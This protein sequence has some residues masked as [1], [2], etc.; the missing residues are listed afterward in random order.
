[1]QS[2]AHNRN[3]RAVIDSRLSMKKLFC[4]LL[5]LIA[6]F[7]AAS[8]EETNANLIQNGDFSELDA[9]SMPVG[10]TRDQWIKDEGT[11]YL[12]VAEDET[13]GNCAAVVNNSANDARFRQV[14]EVEPDSYYHFSADI[15]ASGCDPDGHA[16]TLS[17][18]NTFVYS[19]DV[20]ETNGEWQHVDMYVRTTADQHEIALLLRVGGYS[21]TNTGAAYFD[22]V[23]C[24]KLDA[25]PDNV[26]AQSLE[27]QSASGNSGSDT[28]DTSETPVKRNTEAFLLLSCLYALAIFAIARRSQRILQSHTS[29]FSILLIAF[30]GALI[31]RIVLAL[32]VRG[33][34]TDINC[35]AAW[36]E[37]MFEN[38]AGHFYSKDYF[39]DYP[40]LYM[41]LLGGISALRHLF[42]IGVNSSAHI[43]L[44]KLIPILCDLLGGALIFKYA[45]RK[46]V[47]EKM[48]ALIAA[49]YL[50]NPAALI[51]SAAWGQIDSVFTLLICICAIEASEDKYIPSLIAFAAAMLI[52]PQAML[53]APLGLFAIIVN[54]IRA[55]DCRRTLNALLGVV[56]A[57]GLIYICAF[58]CCISTATGF[59]DAILRPVVW[60]HDLYSGTLGSYEYV[61][62]NALNLYI[63]FDLNW[64]AIASHRAIS[65]I[66]WALFAA[67]YLYAGYL[68]LRGKRKDNLLLLGGLLIYLI[69]CFGPKIHERYMFPAMLL[70]T[71]AYA[72]R[73][74]RRLL[75]SITAMTA[76]AAMNQLLVLQGGMG[77]ANTGHLQESEQWLNIALSAVNVINAL[78]LAWTAWD[79][80]ARDHIMG[81]KAV[82]TEDALFD[83]SAAQKP[84][85]HRLHI[86]RIDLIL[87][88][89][90]TAV[91]SIVAFVNLGTCAAPQ[92]SWIAS[93][94]NET[95]V[96]DLGDVHTYRMIYYG[97]ICDSTF[98]VELSNDARHWTNPAYAKY[99]RNEIFRWIYFAPNAADEIASGGSADDVQMNFV[100]LDQSFPMQTSRYI[101]IT[102]QSAGLTLSEFGFWDADGNLLSVS[103]A[104]HT[105]ADALAASDPNSL[106]DEQDTVAQ[107]PSYFNST[108][109]DEIYHARTA[110]ELKHGMSIYEYTH[111]QLGKVL[112]G[113]GIDL[114]GMTPFGW[115]FMGTLIG[116]LMVPLM[117][118]MAKQ[119]TK[120]VRLSFLA[121]CLMALDSMHF[122][123]TRIAT[124]DSYAVFWIML[125][126]LFMIRY[127]QMDWRQV[128]TGRSLVTLGLC[129][130]TMGV[131]WATKWI[132]LYASVGLAI[133]LFWKLISEIMRAENRKAAVLRAVWTCLF[134]VGFFV[135]IPVLIYYFSYYPQLRCEGASGIGAMF[136]K[137]SVE[138]VVKLQQSMLSYHAG[139]G[140]DTHYFRSP[141]YQWPIIWWPM[142]YYSGNAYVPD[143]MISSISCMGNPAVWW[144]GLIALIALLIY[145]ARS[146]RAK[147]AHLIVLIGFASQF[148][149]WVLV[150]RSTFIYHY[151]A[152]VPFIILCIALML[153]EIGAKRPHLAQYIGNALIGAALVMFIGFYPLESGTPVSRSYA[154]LLRW[155]KW[156]NY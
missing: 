147:R 83:I 19:Q 146:R 112:M 42:G 70:L 138:R 142:W 31:L 79:I 116:V 5:A 47:S 118:L 68:Y 125:M 134:C 99:N 153:Q 131:A 107:T 126:Y 115:R 23:T 54:L 106:I 111:P 26:F 91:Y 16:A 60:I 74:D 140:G 80:C 49:L 66:A 1:M 113:V 35:F 59:F 6:V 156:Y 21:S 2:P 98:T 56:C 64:A 132:G 96:F 11:S 104:D 100:S 78:F 8:A 18:E 34:N 102:A 25:L 86:R 55:K 130:V 62:L 40:P 69:F 137:K 46:N 41:M 121:M 119:L 155:F 77:T 32:R 114:F 75:I 141:W 10:W 93:A 28:A 81:A 24:E 65:I 128:R 29:A 14:I 90:V 17:F 82:E 88:A 135:I 151:F 101:R 43:L 143:G 110:Y 3:R 45:R 109:F 150:P 129:G 152:S 53:F 52:K 4:I 133:L 92:T 84:T 37:R 20:Y 105:G 73:R 67:A 39:C 27:E 108:Y 33:Y 58:I 136:T 117:Y 139:L 148:L 15:S 85:D 122:T 13:N 154:K 149:P 7:C 89:A 76:V 123:Q 144:S 57:L 12:Y 30:G 124:I 145:A 44:L 38:G 120:D 50:L 71:I 36:S 87:M 94:D 48:A 97:G 95:I 127:I 103:I 61:T 72:L 9:D 51:D 22:N 63:L